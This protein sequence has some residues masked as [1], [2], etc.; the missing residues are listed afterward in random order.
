MNGVSSN[1]PI[2][3]RRIDTPISG[4]DNP[5]FT[6]SVAKLIAFW[7]WFW[8]T[9]QRPHTLCVLRICSGAMLLYCHLVLATDLLS[10]LGTEAWIH[11]D[12][13]RELHDGAFGIRDWGRS[14]LWNIDRPSYLYAHHA[15]AIGLAFCYCIGFASRIAIPLSLF[16]QLM[17]LHRLTGTLFGL[18]QIVTYVTFY[19][20]LTPAG[21]R[22]SVDAFLRRRLGIDASSPTWLRCLFPDDHPT[23]AANVGTRLLQLHLCVIY[24]F[25][26]LAKA[27][28]ETW[29]N[30]EA[31]WL[32]L[33]NYEYQSVDM[34]WISRFPTLISAM[35]NATLFWEVFYCA[36]VWPRVT[37]PFVIGMAFAVHAS[38]ACFLGMATFGTMM[39]VANGVFLSPVLFQSKR[40]RTQD[41]DMLPSESSLE[42][43]EAADADAEREFDRQLENPD[44]SDAERERLKAKK[45]KI[46]EAAARVKERY[47]ALKKREAKYEARVKRLRARE[48]RLKEIV[49]KRR[50]RKRS[51]RSQ[52]DGD[53]L[54]ADDQL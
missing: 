46:R 31:V 3:D 28:G 24:L 4:H 20:A 18:D 44:L 37:R 16:L 30:G 50:S 6:A 12:L 27:R 45:R 35:S 8:F 51:K 2:D 33:A 47:H 13:S 23:V 25:G 10:F 32:A 22:F 19:L 14:Y 38:I 5:G 26:G 42:K 36:L 21:A 49:E 1:A 39:I 48:D 7:D 9:P 43:L 52:D 41:R 17:Y 40:Q 11:N 34:T 53:D 54:E 29:W 15:C